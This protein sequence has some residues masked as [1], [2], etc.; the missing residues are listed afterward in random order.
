MLTMRQLWAYI[1]KF[2]VMAP[3]GWPVYLLDKHQVFIGKT[4]EV[5]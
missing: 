1:V 2:T 4:I 5:S 3:F